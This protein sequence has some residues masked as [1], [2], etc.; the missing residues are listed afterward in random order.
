MGRMNSKS[1]A[2]SVV[3]LMTLISCNTIFL[4]KTTPTSTEVFDELWNAVDQKY[5]CFSNKDVDWDEVYTKYRARISDNTSDSD[6]FI[7]LFRMLA[8]LKD[9]HVYLSTETKEWSGY[10]KDPEINFVEELVNHYFG[11][12]KKESGGFQYTIIHDGM[13]GYV[14]Y[15]SFEDSISDEHVEEVLEYCKDC[16]GLILDLRGNYGGAFLNGLT[17]LKYLSSEKELYRTF[18]RHNSSRN[19]LIQSGILFMSSPVIDSK[20]WHKPLIVLID[21]QS[22]SMSSVFAMCMKGCEHVRIVGVK[23]AGGTNMADYF[24]LSNGWF[25]RL[26]T[27]KVISRFGIDYENGVLPDIEIHLDLDEALE[28]KDSIIET[29]CDII[30]S[31]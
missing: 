12:E 5:V 11:E 6:L 17:L 3:I 24:E 15:S 2:I 20:R 18:I 14:L 27:I 13:I 16:Q 9:G 19:D 4:K 26:P 25:Y 28:N 1:I 10:R 23:T 8:E 7:V 30:L 31:Q 22:F 21:N 29:A